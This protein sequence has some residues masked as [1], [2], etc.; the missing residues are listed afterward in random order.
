MKRGL[1][2]DGSL[3]IEPLRGMAVAP[4]VEGQPIARVLV[5]DC[6]TMG[7]DMER[8]EMIELA[9]LGVEVQ[10]GRAVGVWQVLRSWVFDPG[11]PI[12]ETIERLT[13]I[14]NATIADEAVPLDNVRGE[15]DELFRSCDVA[16]AHRAEFD[17]T[18]VCRYAHR[19]A[20]ALWACSMESIPWRDLGFAT[21][22]LYALALEHAFHYEAHRAGP[23]VLALTALL[24]KPIDE[25]QPDGPHY[26]STLLDDAAQPVLHVAAAGSPFGAK[27]QLRAAGCRWDPLSKHWHLVVRVDEREK[28]IETLRPIV[29]QHGGRIKIGEVPA[30]ER[31][32]SGAGPSSWEVQR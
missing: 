21:K 28:A 13:G 7:L 9:V 32:I 25:D 4:K 15:I 23:D 19:A 20:D 27:D 8:D 3:R 16:V 18:F 26:W 24:S 31:Y 6:E 30:E 17:R 1:Q 10:G 5:V 29:Q 22:S 11:E 12:P 14:S 2:D